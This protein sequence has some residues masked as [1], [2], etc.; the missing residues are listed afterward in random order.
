M[1]N[2][3]KTHSVCLYVGGGQNNVIPINLYGKFH[4]KLTAVWYFPVD[5]TH[6]KV[7]QL[8]GREF[9]LKYLSGNALFNSSRQALSEMFASPYPIF[10]YN[11]K[12]QIG[13][14]NGSYQWDMDFQGQ[15]ECELVSIRG[16]AVEANDTAV[17]NIELTPIESGGSQ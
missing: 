7:I 2:D 12:H 3:T 14:L 9:K 10:I 13:G 15:I 5:A 6:D 17:L 4:C 1:C 11:D 8:V 16:D